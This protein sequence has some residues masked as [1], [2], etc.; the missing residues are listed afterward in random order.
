MSTRIYLV[1]ETNGKQHLVEAA[2]PA[3]AIRTVAAE[4]FTATPASAIETGR[5]QKDG[6][7]IRWRA[8]TAP[9]EPMS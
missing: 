4:M 2:T 9:A 7:P 5:L 6:V 8:S 3:E 1:T